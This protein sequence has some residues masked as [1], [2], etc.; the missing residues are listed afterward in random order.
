MCNCRQTDFFKNVFS[1]FHLFKHPLFR[2]VN[3]SKMMLSLV[4]GATFRSLMPIFG[5]LWGG[6]PEGAPMSKTFVL[7]KEFD[8][9]LKQKGPWFAGVN[10]PLGQPNIFVKK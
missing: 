9:F 4:R 6:G 7:L 3:L 10:F 8:A 2:A 1:F 5:T